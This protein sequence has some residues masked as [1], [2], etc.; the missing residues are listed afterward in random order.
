[1]IFGL[2]E[3]RC[4][5]D[6]T[7]DAERH[8]R[9]GDDAAA[10]RPDPKQVE[11]DQC[12]LTASALDA[13]EKR[14]GDGGDT[15]GHRPKPSSV[16]NRDRGERDAAERERAEDLARQVEMP[17]VR[18]SGLRH[19]HL[20]QRE[21]G[22]R[23]RNREQEHAAPSEMFDQ[24]AAERGADREG[25]PVA[26][27]PDAQHAPARRRLRPDHANDRKRGRQ[28]QSRG[29]A[30]DGTATDQHADT[31]REGADEG[32]RRH[33]DRA[34]REGPAPSVKIG[35]QATTEQQHGIDEIV[36]IEHPLQRR[37]TGLE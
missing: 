34:D 3:Q 27:C 9:G 10:E 28:Q 17:A 14:Q 32:S 36:G 29:H 21:G 15:E 33:D 6:H 8:G 24:D 1:M 25:E 4:Q 7:V 18:L 5:K 16:M 19:R 20:R 35:D 26:A 2:P 12:R 37:D 11:G 30:R 22:E 13:E 23:Q 31:G